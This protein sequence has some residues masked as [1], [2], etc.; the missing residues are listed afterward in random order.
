MVS[1]FI[2]LHPKAQVLWEGYQYTGLEGG[3]GSAKSHDVATYLVGEMVARKIRI[4]CAREV[5][6]S[7]ED[8]SKALLEAKIESMGYSGMFKITDKYISCPLTGSKTLFK[9]LG[10]KISKI[11]SIENIDITWLEE[12][13]AISDEGLVVLFPSV[14]RKKGSRIIATWNPQL[15]TDPISVRLKLLQKEGASCKIVHKTYK[16]N[17]YLTDELR[18]QA[19]FSKKHNPEEYQW[20]WLGRIKPDDASLKV[21]IR[22]WL[23]KCVAAYS[24]WYDEAD[25]PIIHAGLDVAESTTGDDNSLAVRRGPALTSCDTWRPEPE[26][27]PAPKAHR[28]AMEYGVV[29][30]FYDA[31]GIGSPLKRDFKKLLDEFKH[32]PYITSPFLFGGAV[33]GK[34]RDFIKSGKN[35]ITNG[36]YFSRLNAQAWWNI[37]QRAINT[38][39]KMAGEDIPLDKCLLINPNIPDIEGL[40]DQLSLCTYEENNAGKI[41]IDKYGGGDESPDKADSVVMAYVRDLRKGLRA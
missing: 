13:H 8:S 7:I 23:E 15:S 28:L 40:L 4:L 37:R 19:E 20:I 10:H 21:I 18:E 12:A 16:D 30:L 34:D 36:N 39:N 31:G 27:G 11:Q 2:T 3:R 22:P 6:D 14:L 33:S 9:G 17:P 41:V 29:K 5:Q 35:S 26:K 1:D 32:K 24:I 38:V 25:S